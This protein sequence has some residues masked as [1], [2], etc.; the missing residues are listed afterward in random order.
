MTPINPAAS[1]EEDLKPRRAGRQRL[2]SEASYGEIEKPL[3]PEAVEALRFLWKAAEDQG[4]YLGAPYAKFLRG[5]LARHNPRTIEAGVLAMRVKVESG[6]VAS[7]KHWTIGG[8]IKNVGK[9]WGSSGSGWRPLTDEEKMPSLKGITV[10][11]TDTLV[12]DSNYAEAEQEEFHHYYK[13]RG[14]GF[15]RV[16]FDNKECQ[17]CG[18]EVIERVLRGTHEQVPA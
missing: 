4:G 3:S 16:L 18:K 5:L 11:E 17:G 2:P 12:V 10:E 8:F 6:E 9:P 15:D 13:C 7:F 1:G 14:C